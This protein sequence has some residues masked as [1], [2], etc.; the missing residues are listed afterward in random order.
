MK[1]SFNLEIPRGLSRDQAMGML[2]EGERSEEGAIFP[3]SKRVA[4]FPVRR[5]TNLI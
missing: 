5:Q 4:S 3:L 2:K 1:A